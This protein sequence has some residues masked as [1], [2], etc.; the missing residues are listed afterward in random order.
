MAPK[1]PLTF[2]ITGCS[3]GL[4]LTLSRIVLA[5]GHHLIATSRKPSRTPDLVAEIE[6][7]GGKWLALDVDDP[8][9]SSS[10]TEDLEKKGTHIDV[11]VN[12]AGFS[13][14]A[15]VETTS[16][17]EL[18]AMMETLYFGPARLIRSVLPYM[19]KRKF[20]VVVNMSSGAGLEGF[21]ST[22]GYASAK[23]ALDGE[24]MTKLNVS[25]KKEEIDQL[26]G[27]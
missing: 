4:G 1:H 15:P 26:T 9:A 5:H 20:G 16:E 13:I 21:E 25:G 8:V 2:L 24:L 7:A 14:H 27:K 12:N 18:R 3:S 23:A 11:L 17:E 22:G 6:A 10:F 19:R